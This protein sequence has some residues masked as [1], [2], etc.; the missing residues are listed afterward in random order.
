M[1]NTRYDYIVVGSG[2]AGLV[3][4]YHASKHGS[5]AII[6]KSEIDC[7]SSFHAQG[8]IA[9]AISTADSPE[10][11]LQDSVEAGRGLCEE[12]ALEVLV[13]S[14]VDEIK[15]LIS[16]GMKFD[17]IDDEIILGLEGGHTNR[18]IL[19]AG[20]DIT[21]AKVTSFMHNLLSQQSNIS[22]FEY[23]SVV[24]LLES[25][26]RCYGVEAISNRSEDIFLMFAKAT[27]LATGGVAR[28]YSRSTNPEASTGDGISLAWRAGATLRDMEFIQFH[29]SALHLAGETAFLISE[30]VRGE[31]AYL[32]NGKGER[33]ML[34]Q[35]P[36]AELAPRDVV[37]YSI[38]Q[39][40]KR[41]GESSV[42]LDLSHLDRD[43]I[44][45]RFKGVAKG[46]ER[47]GLS[48]VDDKI[49]VSPAA[50]YM[51]GGVM[52]SSYGESSV[53]GLY[54][55]GE[56]ASTGVMGANRLASNSLLECI[57]FG[58][59][60]AEHA[61][62]LSY[63]DSDIEFRATTTVDSNRSGEALKIFN[64]LANIMSSY[65]GVVR[66]EAGVKEALSLIESI[67]NRAN[68]IEGEYYS[69]I[70][71]GRLRVCSVIAEAALYRRESRGGHIREDYPNPDNRLK[72][73]S[74]QIKG[75]PIELSSTI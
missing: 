40:L 7:S 25:G 54:S 4:A 27:I 32:V 10:V 62:T 46:L 3:A 67:R 31:G 24:R 47:F 60:V 71:E 42:Y 23:C 33:F 56:L 43:K 21:G 14:G 61:S 16:K 73:H 64:E 44:V 29:P 38:Y 6:S 69:T 55:C 26:G 68:L 48:L 12:E 22:T 19:H 2:L 49:P 59:R 39:E 28:V 70:I 72:R 20:G 18:R 57:V 8:G 75:S 17:Q 65:V 36:K 50:H 5:V 37:A 9:A 30:A 45:N 41:S 74:L 15:W 53:E 52:A 35:H 51:V 11:H 1:K 63:P 13:N 66:N 58:H 34:N